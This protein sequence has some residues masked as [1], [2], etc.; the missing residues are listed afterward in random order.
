MPNVV[1]GYCRISTM[2]QKLDRQVENIKACYPNAVIVAEAYT[3]TTT[4][5]PK[6]NQLLEQVKKEVAKGTEVT[7]VFD[8]VSRM[9][10]NATEGFQTYQE[11]FHLGVRLVFLK[12][13]HID[14]YNFIQALQSKVA[15]TGTDIDIILA[16]VNEYL[17]RLAARQIEL[18]FEQAQSEVDHLHQ[19]TSEGVRQ[20]Q[21]LGKQIG[22]KAGTKAGQGFKETKKALQCKEII[23]KHSKSFRGTLTDIECLKLTG[24]AR[25]TFYKYKRELLE[26]P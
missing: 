25:N 5:R 6:F 2:K 4:D 1:Y 9:S 19:R 21:A 11:L 7:L 12:E 22:R 14:T 3:G 18:A 8:E 26:Y 24:L 13:R 17:M 10:R 16:A 15:L 23:L 20:A